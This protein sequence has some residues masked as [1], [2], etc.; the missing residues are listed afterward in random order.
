MILTMHTIYIGCVALRSCVKH[1]VWSVL[2]PDSRRQ[3]LL[4]LLG[5]IN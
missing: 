2:C 3:I 5:M 4:V 1:S